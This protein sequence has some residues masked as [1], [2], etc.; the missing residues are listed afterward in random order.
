MRSYISLAHKCK[1]RWIYIHLGTSDIAET[2]Y[3]LKQPPPRWCSGDHRYLQL[4]EGKSLS[5]RDRQYSASFRRLLPHVTGRQYLH[6]ANESIVRT[7]FSKE[8]L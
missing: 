1:S 3:F 7:L 6:K 2:T 4:S 5:L 8:I